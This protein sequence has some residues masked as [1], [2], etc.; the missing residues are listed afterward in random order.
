MKIYINFDEISGRVKKTIEKILRKFKKDDEFQNFE[1]NL[2]F[3]RK[4]Y[5]NLRNLQDSL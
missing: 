5:V 1:N 3:L 4:F 2:S